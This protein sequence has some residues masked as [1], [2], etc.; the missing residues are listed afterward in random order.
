MLDKFLNK[1]KNKDNAVEEKED[2]ID[3]VNLFK[4]TKYGSK[5]ANLSLE[6]NAWRMTSLILM[7]SSF[8]LAYSLMQ[9]SSHTTTIIIPHQ[10]LAAGKQ[11]KIKDNGFED[12]EYLGNLALA[13]IQ[14]LLN[15]TSENVQKQYG[16]FL[17]R[18]TTE[19]YGKENV[20]L[21]NEAKENSSN[22]V[23]QAFYPL[24]I[25][26]NNN[27]SAKYAGVAAVSG[28]L[29]RYEGEKQVLRTKVSYILRYK[30][31]A[32]LLKVDSVEFKEGKE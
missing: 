32:G 8:I 24:S 21:L 1:D 2:L 14:L 27:A 28:I 18:A 15:W 13:D 4:Q 3:K 31:V 5:I 19:L 20:R 9:V 7:A 6:L 25:K 17:N 23:T 12:P 22:A 29:V 11:F 26:Q 16:M 10:V 30:D